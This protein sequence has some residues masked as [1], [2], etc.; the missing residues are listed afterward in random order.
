[1]NNRIGFNSGEASGNNYL[2]DPDLVQRIVSDY[3]QFVY[4]LIK[5]R[6]SGELPAGGMTAVLRPRVDALADIFM[7]RNPEYQVHR[8]WNSRFGVGIAIRQS[9]GAYW[10]QNKGT[11]DEDP[12]KA[13][14]G[15]LAA[16][17][18]DAALASRDDPDLAGI[19]INSKMEKVVRVLL[20]THKRA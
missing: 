10:E 6:S 11:Y 9:L 16:S 17:V 13:L 7:G 1:M 14:F 15:W 2:G 20:G 12:G 5:K 8:T 18:V 3:V 19:G 4:G